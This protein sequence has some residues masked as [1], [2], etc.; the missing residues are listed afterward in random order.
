EIIEEIQRESREMVS[1]WKGKLPLPIPMVP[2]IISFTEFMEKQKT[3]AMIASG[4]IPFAVDM[5]DVE[6]VE[7]SVVKDQTT[8][9]LGD[10]LDTVENTFVTLIGSIASNELIDIGLIDN[11]STRFGAFKENVDLYAKDSGEIDVF[12]E[13]LQNLFETR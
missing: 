6:P 3:K 1:A 10:L 2:E 12:L 13:R 5:E 4:G 8:L 9:I 7:L 11:A